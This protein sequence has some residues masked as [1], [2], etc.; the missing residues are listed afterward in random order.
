MLIESVIN[1]GELGDEGRVPIV[2][3]GRLAV[4]EL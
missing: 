4:S 3:G 1:G 2:K